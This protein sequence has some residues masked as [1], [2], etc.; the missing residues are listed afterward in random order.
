M[1]RAFPSHGSK[2]GG[3]EVAAALWRGLVKAELQNGGD[4]VGDLRFS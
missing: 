4:E 3:E 1:P 2:L